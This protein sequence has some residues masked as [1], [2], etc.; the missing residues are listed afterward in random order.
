MHRAAA[1][2][3]GAGL[4]AEQLRHHDLRV[5]A[6]RQRLA[7]LAVGGDQ[8]VVV[9]HHGDGADDRRLLADREMQEAADLGLHVHLLRAL[10]EVPDQQHL[11]EQLD[12]GLLVGQVALARG[13]VGLAGA[14]AARLLRCPLVRHRCSSWRL[15]PSGLAPPRRACHLP[16]RPGRRPPRSARRSRRAP[17]PRRSP[18]AARPSRSAIWTAFVSAFGCSSQAAAASITLS[19]SLRSRPAA[20]ACR[21]PASEND[22]TLPICFAN[23]AA[24]I[25]VS[26]LPGHGS[27]Q[28]IAGSP[29]SAARRSTSRMPVRAPGPVRPR[30]AAV[31]LEQRAEQD[32]LPLRR[33]VEQRVDALGGEIRVR[34]TEIEI[35]R[36]ESHRAPGISG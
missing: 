12:G 16:K 22:T 23:V 6:A 26:V 14:P 20:N 25:A 1:A 35:E 19:G 2:A 28:R 31:D 29:Y 13:A 30:V 9:A 8:V 34:R 36:P 15:P 24:R 3:R 5:G 10:L 18:R 27:G 4:L 11:L 33:L 17:P 32:R 21:N 7:V